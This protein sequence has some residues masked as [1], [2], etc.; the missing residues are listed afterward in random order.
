MQ[1][2][3]NSSPAS[4]KSFPNGTM[5]KLIVSTSLIIWLASQINLEKVWHHIQNLNKGIL[6]L[7]T[8]LLWLTLITVSKRWQLVV[9]LGNDP[10]TPYPPLS[11]LT[12]A[13]F[14]GAFFN[15]FLPSSVGGD[16]Y[17]ILAI[18]R[19]GASLGKAVSGVIFDRLW[20]F[21]SLGI[22]CIFALPAEAELL[23]DSDLKWP[24]LITMMLFGSIVTG[25]I[26]LL[27]IPAKAYEYSFWRSFLPFIHMVRQLKHQKK[28]FIN[29]LATAIVASIFL[30]LGLQVLMFAFHIPLL[31]WQGA[32][33]LP[34]V[35]LLTSLPVSFAGWGLR[36]GAMILALGIYGVAQEKAMALSLV[37]G[38]LQIISGFPGFILWVLQKKKLPPHCS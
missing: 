10:E 7:V 9:R 24:L 17:R 21:L 19:F 26:I 32:A 13:T 29:L 8:I 20:G 12:E 22:L 5:I 33:I 34:V 15:Q 1:P 25:G 27:F 3:I 37:Y 6:F 38:L 28:V 30:I 16:F 31:W 4:K 35:M 11:S 23:L 2:V 36:E 18:R 14:I